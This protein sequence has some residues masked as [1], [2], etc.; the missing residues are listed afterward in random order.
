MLRT[1]TRNRLG[2]LKPLFFVSKCFGIT[3]PSLVPPIHILWKIYSVILAAVSIVFYILNVLLKIAFSVYNMNL[4]LFFMDIVC[5][6]FLVTGDI[7]SLTYVTFMKEKLTATFMETIAK[8]DHCLGTNANDYK[9]KQRIFLVEFLVAMVYMVANNLYNFFVFVLTVTLVSPTY[10][11]FREISLYWTGLNLLQLYNFVLIIRNKFAL[12]NRS[13]R[14][15]AISIRNGAFALTTCRIDVYLEKYSEY[16]DLVDMFNRIF[17]HRT[18]WVIGFVIIMT[19]EA[20]QIGLNCFGHISL[21][22]VGDK[23]CSY[24]GIANMMEISMYM[25]NKS[26]FRKDLGCKFSAVHNSCFSGF[27]S[28]VRCSLSSSFRSG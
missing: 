6:V 1:P 24:V 7:S 27:C 21:Q 5:E 9:R 15:E 4:F 10:A 13:L 14:R 17:G 18:Y 3:A 28:D 22:P 8:D 16:C 25:V 11:F 26:R 12:L 2:Y 23:S 20:F 19:V